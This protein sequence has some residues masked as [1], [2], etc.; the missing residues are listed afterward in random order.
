MK[1]KK[2]KPTLQLLY[3]WLACDLS[4]NTFDARNSGQSPSNKTGS[5]SERKPK[6]YGAFANGRNDDEQK[7]NRV[8]G[9]VA[10]E[11]FPPQGFS[12]SFLYAK[13]NEKI[14][15]I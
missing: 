3:F 4:L 13:N 6:Y 14:R 15:M 8:S 1:Q 2:L 7:R 12:F 11:K 10:S 9:V 5:P